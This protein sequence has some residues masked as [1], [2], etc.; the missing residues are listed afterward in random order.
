MLVQVFVAT[1]DIP[2]MW[3]RDSAVQ[4]A[5]LVA[6]MSRRPALRRLVEGAVRTQVRP[7]GCC[8]DLRQ[9]TQKQSRAVQSSAQQHLLQPVPGLPLPLLT[10]SLCRARPAVPPL[11]CCRP[12]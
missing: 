9:Q 5:P 4:L 3:I 8:H 12:L 1:G 7:L 2:Y 11:C 6:R 10:A